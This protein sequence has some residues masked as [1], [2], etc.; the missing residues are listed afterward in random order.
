MAIECE[1]TLKALKRYEQILVAY[2]RAIKSA[3]VD[4]VIWVSPTPEISQRLRAIITGIKV[5]R[6]AGQVVM[7]EPEK[8]HKNL[9]F[10]DYG[11]WPMYEC[12][13]ES[14]SKLNR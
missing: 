9:V 4:I 3:K 7:I 8:H 5:V 1:R 10:T 14:S 11:Q 12:M 13:H 6:I 2:L